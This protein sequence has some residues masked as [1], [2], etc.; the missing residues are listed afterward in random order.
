MRPRPRFR[1]HRRSTD[2]CLR[3]TRQPLP[4]NWHLPRLKRG[5]G[6]TTGLPMSTK[7]NFRTDAS[8]RIQRSQTLIMDMSYLK[9]QRRRL[10]VSI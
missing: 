5:Q 10:S 8:D 4:E 9:L 3:G 2:R 6:T 1:S 7:L